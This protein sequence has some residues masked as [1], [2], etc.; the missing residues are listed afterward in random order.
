MQ[1]LSK[2]FLA[3]LTSLSVSFAVPPA[4]NIYIIP[5]DN[6][7]SEP[8]ISWL[9]DAFSD[10]ISSNLLSQDRVYVK[11][12]SNLEDVMSNRS[13][14]SQ[15]KPGTKNFLVLGKF[16]R[17]LDKILLSIQLIDIATWDEID[18]R[19]VSGYYNQIDDLN[20]SLTQ[21]VKTMLTPYPVSYTHLPLP[22]IYSV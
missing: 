18:S 2:Y 4:L 16:E 10:M 3:S 11:N 9:S 6:T 14:L 15:Q 5:F 13:L 1:I 19:K 8:S 7:K 12:Q 20:T 17:S 21:L 22:T